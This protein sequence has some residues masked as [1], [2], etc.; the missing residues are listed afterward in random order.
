MC[1][2][3]RHDFYQ[4]PTTVIASLFLKKIIKGSA[5]IAFSAKSVSLDL[6]TSDNK[7]YES[8]I[9]LFGEIDTDKST[10]KIMG[11]KMEMTLVKADRTS[12]PVL[13]NDEP[14]TEIIQV[15]Q[16]GRA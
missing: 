15:G 13:R 1:T 3:N 11:T 4:T 2:F 12:W 8:E 7:R 6:R 16:A 5:K 10:Y 9:P 14:V